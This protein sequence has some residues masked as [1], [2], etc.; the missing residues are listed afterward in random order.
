MRLHPL[1]SQR[2]EQLTAKAEAVSGSKYQQNSSDTYWHVSSPL[3]K[4]WATNSLSLLEK[5]FGRDSIHFENLAKHCELFVGWENQFLE[6][7]SIFKAARE[8]YEGGYLFN[9]KALVKA[10]VLSEAFEQARDLLKSGYKDL[11]CILCRVSL[12]VTLKALCESKDISPGKLE[13]MNVDLCKAGVYNMT[14]QKQITAWADIGNNAAHGKWDEYTLNDVNSM[15]TG[16]E[17]LVAD[18]LN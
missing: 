12:D 6:C 15:F 3:F 1:I 10:E 11:A 14:K 9:V 5:S 7:R 13:R 18:I 4:E 16:V 8:D 17:A 2:F